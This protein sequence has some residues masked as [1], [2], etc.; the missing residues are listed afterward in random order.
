MT[1]ISIDADARGVTWATLDR[2]DQ[3][4]AV[5]GEMIAALVAAAEA[6]AG[7]PAQRVLV[8]R[9]E[10][11]HFS[12]GADVG[13]L[14]EESAKPGR[15]QAR[16]VIDVARALKSLPK[17]TVALVQGACIG[18]AI[19]IIGACDIV[20]AGEDAFFQIPEVRL[21]FGLSSST[22]FLAAAVGARGLRRYGLTGER[23]GAGEARRLGL[24]HEVAPPGRLEQAAASIIDALL[25]GGPEAQAATKQLIA[26]VAE[27]PL[28]AE[29]L[30]RMEAGGARA[31]ASDEA[32]EGFAALKEKRKPAWVPN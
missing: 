22:P 14:R 23:F 25:L 31:R 24:V 3:R 12:A 26:D 7:D 18:G 8:L 29:I 20:V 28:A 6:C 19:A 11:A 10:G 5:N 13:W 27:P 2:A 16:T 30:A 17:P 21:G 1:H 32:R 9:G 15:A 4:N